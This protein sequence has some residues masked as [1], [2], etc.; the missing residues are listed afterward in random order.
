MLYPTSHCVPQFYIMQTSNA[1]ICAD[2]SFPWETPCSLVI[3]KPFPKSRHRLVRNS[4]TPSEFH[5][6]S[7]D[8]L[9]SIL[10]MGERWGLIWFL[11]LSPVFKDLRKEEQGWRRDISL[12]RERG[13]RTQFTALWELTYCT[14]FLCHCA[15]CLS[16]KQLTYWQQK[17]D[18]K[19]CAH[20]LR[21]SEE[22]YTHCRLT[23]LNAQ[24]AIVATRGLSINK[25]GQHKTSSSLSDKSSNVSQEVRATSSQMKLTLPLIKMPNCR[26]HLWSFKYTTKIH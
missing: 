8:K 12:H 20:I 25:R 2:L 13:G 22:W 18:L 26:K 7:E 11:S 16:C 5:L 10:Q 4:G 24:Y 21:S 3:Q 1:C 17:P 14:S 6:I 9:V 19:E 23:Y 15:E